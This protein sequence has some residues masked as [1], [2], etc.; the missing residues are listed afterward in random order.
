MALAMEAQ[1]QP[2]L[3]RVRQNADDAWHALGGRAVL[4]TITDARRAL[5]YVAPVAKDAADSYRRAQQIRHQLLCTSGARERIQLAEQR[6]E[7]L[8][9]LNRAIDECN[10][11]G[12]DLLNIPEGLVRFH[13]ELNDR[14]MSLVWRLGEPVDSAWQMLQVA[15]DEVQTRP[16]DGAA[17][18]LPGELEPALPVQAAAR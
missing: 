3:A 1:M 4:F 13:A 8:R 7:A 10:A 17:R 14:R 12:A 15:T 11:V 6:D 18:D 5:R 16:D 2:T 9:K